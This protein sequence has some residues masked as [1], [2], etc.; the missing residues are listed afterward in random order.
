MNLT[1]QERY[2][3]DMLRELRPFEEIRITKDKAGK[4]SY[5]FFVTRTQ[6]VVVNVDNIRKPEFALCTTGTGVV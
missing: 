2:V 5:D 3:I 6:K 4:P 1:P